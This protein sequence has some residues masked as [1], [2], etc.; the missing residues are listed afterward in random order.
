MRQSY[1]VYCV[2]RS[3]LLCL[4]CPALDYVELAKKLLQIFLK[5]IFIQRYLIL[6][7]FRIG[8]CI[9]GLRSRPRDQRPERLTGRVAS[10]GNAALIS[11]FS[12]FFLFYVA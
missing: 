3:I 2:Y 12:N 10:S 11:T 6:L 4:L 1:I 8:F 9:M 5:L 7:K